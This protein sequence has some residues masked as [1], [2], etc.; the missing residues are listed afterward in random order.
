VKTNLFA[1]ESLNLADN[2]LPVALA[3]YLQAYAWECAHVRDAGREA[4]DDQIIWQYAK[5]RK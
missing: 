4:A 5:V 3:R 2:Q 1:Q